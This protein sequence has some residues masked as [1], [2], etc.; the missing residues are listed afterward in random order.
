MRWRTTASVLTL[1]C[2][3][4]LWEKWIFY[5]PGPERIIE[6]VYEDSTL[7]GCRAAMPKFIKEKVIEKRES[8]SEREYTVT[9]AGATV[10]VM[11]WKDKNH[12]SHVERTL[13]YCLPSTVDPY[14]DP[15]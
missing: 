4:V 7:S 9:Q 12:P 2:S 3:W 5:N 10:S 15:R 6:A 13:Y 14:H 1:L 8:Y 11:H